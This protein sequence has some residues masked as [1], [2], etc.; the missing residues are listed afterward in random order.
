MTMLGLLVFILFIF[1]VIIHEIAHGAVALKFGDDTAYL[2]GRLTLDPVKHIDPVMTI[3]VP[4]LLFYTTGYALGGAK[5]VP[6][7]PLRLKRPRKDMIWITFAG[8]ASNFALAA[9]FALGFRLSLFLIPQQIPGSL[10]YLLQQA[11]GTIVFYNI[12]LAFFNLIPIPP[13]DG[14]RI[15]TGLLPYNLAA[16]FQ[17]LEQFGLFIVFAL[18]YSGI[19]IYIFLPTML[20][21][22]I[23]TGKPIG[24]FDLFAR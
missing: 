6:V 11:L 14:G 19:L 22:Y 20:I 4:L 18:L 24:Y 16:K 1:S 15:L 10:P 13:L 23:L 21:G 7:N 2:Q 12:F 9:I 8:P 5:P 3:I 17:K